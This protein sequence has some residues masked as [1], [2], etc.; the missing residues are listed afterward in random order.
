[1]PPKYLI[2]T[3]CA[4]HGCSVALKAQAESLTKCLPSAVCRLAA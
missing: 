1:M 2:E 4:R 3:S